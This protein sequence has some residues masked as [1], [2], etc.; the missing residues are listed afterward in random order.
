MVR[1]MRGWKKKEGEIKFACGIRRE[2]HLPTVEVL[3]SFG[4]A[5]IQSL[6]RDD[7]QLLVPS[8]S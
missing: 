3:H 8:V 1:W 4:A 5:Q 6:Y 2:G 7:K